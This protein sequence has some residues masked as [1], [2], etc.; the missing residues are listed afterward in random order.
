M[1]R[2]KKYIIDTDELEKLASYGCTTREM[3]DFFGC[4]ENVISGSYQEFTTKGRNA[5]KKRL[6]M[7]QIKSALGGNVT[8]MIWLGKNY[9][10]QTDKTETELSVSA[11]EIAKK[12]SE[13]VSSA[14]TGRAASGN[15]SVSQ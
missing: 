6:R 11:N 3:A 4:P 8:M 7:A 12:F 13:M 2:P 10:D 5:L 15:K 9:L 14:G 1:A